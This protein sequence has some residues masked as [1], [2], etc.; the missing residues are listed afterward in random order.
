LRRPDQVDG[1][2]HAGEIV[3]SEGDVQRIQEFVEENP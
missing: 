1:I 2:I 3:L